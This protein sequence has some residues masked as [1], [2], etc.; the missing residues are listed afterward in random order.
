MYKQRH[1]EHTACQ[2]V[3]KTL[4]LSLFTSNNPFPSAQA[5][6]DRLEQV[7]HAARARRNYVLDFA[8]DIIAQFSA[9]IL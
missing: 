7:V 1:T 5:E 9:I 8:Q 6:V 3:H 2:T 4:F